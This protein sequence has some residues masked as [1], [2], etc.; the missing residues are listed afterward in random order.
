[1]QRA[2]DVGDDTER[3][4]TG[5]VCESNT[6][7]LSI[8]LLL[9][10]GLS[11]FVAYWCTTL[12][13]QLQESLSRKICDDVCVPN[14]SSAAWQ[15]DAWANNTN[16]SRHGEELLFVYLYNLTN[17]MDILN[18]SAV[19]LQFL[20]P[21][22][23]Q[24][25]R[26]RYKVA[27][28]NTSVQ[29]EDREE[30]KFLANLSKG[31]ETD[32]II[33]FD[34]FVVGA[35][36]LFHSRGVSN[37]SDLIPQ[38][39]L[40][41]GKSPNRA[42]LFRSSTPA[43]LLF[44]NTF[45]AVRKADS[46]SWGSEADGFNPQFALFP[47]CSSDIECSA[48]RKDKRN[49]GMG[50]KCDLDK[51]FKLPGGMCEDPLTANVEV[52][53]QQQTGQENIAEI[54]QMTKWYGNESI[55][56]DTI[57]RPG[58]PVRV[59]GHSP[60]QFKLDLD[61]S[62]PLK[63]FDSLLF[64]GVPVSY[65]SLGSVSN[66]TTYLYGSVP[67]DSS[68]TDHSLKG[69]VNMSGVM[70]VRTGIPVPYAMTQ[71]FLHD[72]DPVWRA[73]VHCTG[74]PNS[75]EVEVEAI[76]ASS[77]SSLA[78]A[79]TKEAS[80]TKPASPTTT[81]PASA[82][83]DYADAMAAGVALAHAS[84][85][86]HP[87][88]GVPN[89]N[90]P[91]PSKGD[92]YQSIFEVEPWTG[93]VIKSHSRQ[94]LNLQVGGAHIF[95]NCT[96]DS[97]NDY[98]WKCVKEMLVP[99]ALVQRNYSIGPDALNDLRALG[100]D[101]QEL[102]YYNFTVIYLIPVFVVAFL[103]WAVFACLEAKRAR[104]KAQREIKVPLLKGTKPLPT[105][106]E[107][108]E[109]VDPL[110]S[111]Q[112]RRERVL[113]GRKWAFIAVYFAVFVDT[114]GFGLIIPS[115]QFIA[116]DFVMKP[117]FDGLWLGV[118]NSAYSV[119]QCFGS[120]I[121]GVASDYIGR[122]PVITFCLFGT[123]VTLFVLGLVTDM[124]FLLIVRVLDGA[125]SATIGVCQAYVTDLTT[126]KER[127]FYIG[128]VSASAGLGIV[129]G[130]GLGG[131]LVG[132]FGWKVTCW[133]G[134]SLSLIN[135]VLAMMFIKESLGMQLEVDSDEE[136][137][138]SDDETENIHSSVQ[139]EQEEENLHP[140]CIQVAMDD[141]N[142]IFVFVC[143]FC[144][145]IG[146]TAFAS[147]LVIWAGVTYGMTP[148]SIGWLFT[149]FGAA[150]TLAQILLSGP[151]SNKVGDKW[152]TF[153]GS[154][155]RGG[156]LLMMVWVPTE[157][158]FITAVML[159]AVSGSLIQPCLS[160]LITRFGTRHTY[161]VLQGTFQALGALSRTVTPLVCGVLYDINIDWP[162]TWMGAASMFLGAAVIVFLR[163]PRDPESPQKE[164]GGGLI[165]EALVEPSMSSLGEKVSKIG[166]KLSYSEH[167][168]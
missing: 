74:C 142:I 165:K 26:H 141:P 90:G 144:A 36:S 72:M 112:S 164:E 134:A 7:K 137:E 23:Y 2:S 94:Q 4:N 52:P 150:M 53:H 32:K 91:K 130:P 159:I 77:P 70:A 158:L 151:C 88:R 114:F 105:A 111:Q 119:A 24:V 146:Y 107:Y 166:H 13:T 143:Y 10:F 49:F 154:A 38:T 135:F 25:T 68:S 161:G 19:E 85:A 108:E 136:E 69:S 62:I 82:W 104:A 127:T 48:Y 131:I 103:I 100:N 92:V 35:A 22:V 101:A 139:K 65:D 44:G 42:C 3:N 160:S 138:D 167:G 147:Y 95:G 122:R 33:S 54:A 75:G 66:V 118:I 115:L 56:L 120:I 5:R 50:D 121:C 128:L 87:L 20:G 83:M 67:T 129:I 15:K 153:I 59:S 64:R 60:T 84:K 45:D 71:P 140:S 73:L 37:R 27:Y 106:E 57:E 102:Y 162:F 124:T 117:E 113:A 58:E 11:G 125:L 89:P 97:A 156:S 78:S 16:A 29:Y 30:Y 126:K 163:V 132:S 34:P 148:S 116:E 21:Y 79:P 99:V 123:V 12:H 80:R 157:A 1:M 152:T 110:G 39:S 28:K 17:S 6:I 145:Q 41:G 76:F 43:E 40:C 93:K 46:V 63:V 61:K 96:S 55:L 81:E 18:G 109:M 168:L 51:G 155:L 149:G 86:V 14:E 47:H 31:S 133:T 98:P 9:G 8:L